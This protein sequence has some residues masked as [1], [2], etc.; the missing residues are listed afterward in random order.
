MTSFPIGLMAVLGPLLTAAFRQ[1]AAGLS[2]ALLMFA[3]QVLWTNLKTLPV[4]LDP[5]IGTIARRLNAIA[6]SLMAWAVLAY[7]PLHTGW[8]LG[9]RAP[10]LLS[11]LGDMSASAL[12]C[13][14]FI[15]L[16]AARSLLRGATEADAWRGARLNAGIALGLVGATWL[17]G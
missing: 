11:A 7:R 3:V 13:T 12:G 14:A 4:D 16:L 10:R 5:R 17:A 15:L 6:W 8:L 1:L 9:H 2:I